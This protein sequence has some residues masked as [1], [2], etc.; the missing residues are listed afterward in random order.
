MTERKKQMKILLRKYDGKYYVW[1]D[2]IYKKDRFYVVDDYHGHVEVNLWHIIA[3]KD[4]N[5]KDF[6]V[7]SR[8]GEMIKNDPASIEAHYAAR[9]AQRNC[10]NCPSLKKSIN[11]S[12]GANFA[13]NDDGTYNVN[14]T[15]NA[16][17]R[18]GRQWYNSPT[19]DSKEA[20]K[21]CTFYE[22]RN[23]GVRPIEDIFTQYPGLFDKHVSVDVLNDKKFP[24]ECM[25]TGYFEY[26]LKCRN[27]VKACVNEIGIV[28]HFIVK[29]RH[30]SYITFYSAKYDKLFFCLDGR[31]Y[32]D[33]MP[34]DM[35][36]TKYNQAKAKI[37]T[38]YK[39]EAHK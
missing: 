4:D 18:C 34:Y 8:C 10:F 28:D 22:C 1:K 30:H 9:E 16:Y 7:C 25:K 23:G 26:D 2:A 6:V 15:Y 24:Y 32:T 27:T 29:V 19:I 11:K 36:E 17:L 33:L 5:R 21:I 12:L 39:E 14:E 35:S 3:I 13:K 38:L 31:N 20:K 37:S